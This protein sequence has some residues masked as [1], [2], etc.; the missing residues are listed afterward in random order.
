[1]SRLRDVETS[2][3]IKLALITHPSIGGMDVAVEVVNGIVILSGV[4]ENP[5]QKELATEIARQ[6]GGIDIRNDVKILSEVARTQGLIRRVAE[7][8]STFAPEDVSIR[9][10]VLGDLEAD[11]RVNSLM[12]NVDEMAGVVRL[13]GIQDSE[14]AKLRAEEI[15]SRVAGVTLVVN[16]IEVRVARE[17]RAA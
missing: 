6:Y 4:V 14:V 7:Q 8:A 5:T 13:S 9:E 15:A 17:R 16:D 1:M 2:A 3:R 12:V 10:R 11:S